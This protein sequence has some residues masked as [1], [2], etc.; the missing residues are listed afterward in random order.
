MCDYCQRRAVFL[1]EAINELGGTLRLA[2][3]S[4]HDQAR[5]DCTAHGIPTITE[6]NPIQEH[7]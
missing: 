3:R 6:L 5:H 4:H 7:R 2:C 1:A